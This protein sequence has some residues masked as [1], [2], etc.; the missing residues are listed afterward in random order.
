MITLLVLAVVRYSLTLQQRCQSHGRESLSH[1][2]IGSGLQERLQTCK[3]SGRHLDFICGV[4]NLEG[5]SC[6][7]IDAVPQ[8]TRRATS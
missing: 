2:G 6:V 8:V 5:C 4:A 3:Q 7:S 1:C